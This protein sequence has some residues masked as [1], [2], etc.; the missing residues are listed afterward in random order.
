MHFTKNGDSIGNLLG[1]H[2]YD[3]HASNDHANFSAHEIALLAAND[4]IGVRISARYFYSSSN[5]DGN[6]TFSGYFIG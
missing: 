1:R 5:Y 3:H 6:P 4:A 2:Y